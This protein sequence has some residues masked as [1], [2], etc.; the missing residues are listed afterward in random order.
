MCEFDAL[1]VAKS[2]VMH[3]NCNLK[4]ASQCWEGGI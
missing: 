3:V 2:P 4:P 1:N